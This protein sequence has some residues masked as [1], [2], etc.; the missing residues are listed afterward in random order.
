[1]T[2]HRKSIRRI[3]NPGDFHEFTFSC[4]RRIPLLSNDDWRQML[5][6]GFDR[7]ND[8]YQ[9]RRIAFV[10][11]PD[12][13][14]LLTFPITHEPRIDLFLKAVKR[15]FAG[16][17]KRRLVETRSRLLQR[18][19]I[20]ERPGVERFRFWQEG[21]GYDRNLWSE[22]AVLGSIGYIHLNPVRRQLCDRAVDWKWSSA[23]RYLQENAPVDEDLPAISGLPPE[24]FTP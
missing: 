16:R 24:F 14:H 10:F 15:P 21:A 2:G 11:M 17:I 23:A 9:F 4:F 3:L 8:I 1:M 7:A 6:R 5:A 19:T 13:V 12:H 18:L 22:A 20:R